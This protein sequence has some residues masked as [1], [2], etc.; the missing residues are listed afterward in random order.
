M[1]LF[2][3]TDGVDELDDEA[4]EFLASISAVRLDIQFEWYCVMKN[5]KL[6]LYATLHTQMRRVVYSYPITFLRNSYDM[7]IH[8]IGCNLFDGIVANH[9]RLIVGDLFNELNDGMLSDDIQLFDAAD[10]NLFVR[11]LH[12]STQQ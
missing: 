2:S 3:V 12:G 10:E 5:E 4:I 6:I 8:A 1:W 7:M 11:T 9:K